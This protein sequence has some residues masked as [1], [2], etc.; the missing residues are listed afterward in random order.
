MKKGLINIKEISITVL[1]LIMFFGVCLLVQQL[2]NI[3]SLIPM[4]FI[5]AVFLVS[6]YTSGYFLGIFASLVSVLAVNYAFTFP[7][8]RF[9]FT[10]S[11]N[12]IS[13]IIMLIV[14]IMTSTMTTQIKRH[15]QKKREIEFTDC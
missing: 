7:H 1:I 4:F 9:N 15:E 6:R 5:L 8:F 10:I 2:L 12:L 3:H 14:T 13:A 11:E